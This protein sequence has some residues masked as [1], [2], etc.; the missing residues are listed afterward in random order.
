MHLLKRMMNDEYAITKRQL[1]WLLLAAGIVILAVVVAAEIINTE[2]NEFGTVQKLA[3]L[4]GVVSVL[5][6][7]TLLPLGDRPA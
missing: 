4:L 5:V 6:G 7:V 3:A 1:G 2:T